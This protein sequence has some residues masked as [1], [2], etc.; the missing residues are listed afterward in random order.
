MK[1][2]LDCLAT[3]LG[4]RLVWALVLAWHPRRQAAHSSGRTR[5]L[6]RQILARSTYK[7][8]GTSF[9]ATNVTYISLG[10]DKLGPRWAVLAVQWLC[11][12]FEQLIHSAL[13]AATSLIVRSH[14]S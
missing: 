14:A 13:D 1:S 12:V 11:Y 9:T 5:A 3:E 7:T 10:W 8:L 2:L 4:A 6:K